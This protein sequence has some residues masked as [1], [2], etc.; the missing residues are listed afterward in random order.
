MG[1]VRT[2]LQKPAEARQSFETVLSLEPNHQGATAELIGLDL[3][4]GKPALALQRAQ[5]LV[6]K[7]PNSAA[8]RFVEARVHASQKDWNQAE[9]ALL[10]AIELEPNQVAAYALLAETFRARK[11]A[12]ATL[13]RV[14]SLLARHPG[15]E[16]AVVVAG[17]FYA[18]VGNAAKTRDVYEAFLTIKPNAAEILNNLA[19]LHFDSF[20]D[21]D[22]ALEIA[23]RARTAAPAAPAIAD[24]L[25]WMLYQKKSYAEALPLITESATRLGQLAE[26]QYH[27]G[28]VNLRLGHDEAARTA[29]RL[30][31]A[32]TGDYAGKD[33][34]RREL[35]ELEKRLPAKA[36]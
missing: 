11:D 35:A 30:A 25:G 28:M 23:R 21:V 27:L 13:A 22:R 4:D 19:N 8:A 9:A 18:S 32:G 3:K 24:T 7:A 15:E 20:K 12:P 5:T 36:P 31:A 34:A 16:L 29:L 6:A 17:Q 14:D 1:V 2:Q 26:V 33:E 10:K